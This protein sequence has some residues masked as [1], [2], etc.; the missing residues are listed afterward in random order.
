MGKG[1]KDS[2]VD[3]EANGRAVLSSSRRF[4]GV[5]E[6][7]VTTQVSDNGPEARGQPYHTDDT[8]GFCI[9]ESILLVDKALCST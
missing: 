8:R 3:A 6:V 9:T 7:F 4:K 2:L 5:E 1:V